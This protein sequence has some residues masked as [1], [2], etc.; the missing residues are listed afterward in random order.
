V[1]LTRA[2][3]GGGYGGLLD[4]SPC[5]RRVRLGGSISARRP[6][7]RDHGEVIR[8]PPKTPPLPADLA[9][10][11]RR[12]WAAA[13]AADNGYGRQAESLAPLAQIALVAAGYRPAAC[14]FREDVAW[15]ALP[16]GW[17]AACRRAGL[18]VGRGGPAGSIIVAR[19]RPAYDQ[20][21]A[22]ARAMRSGE[23][24]RRGGGLAGPAARLGEALG[25]PRSAIEAYALDR[26]PDS[27][28]SLFCGRGSLG[29]WPRVL[30]PFVFA[31]DPDG[32]AETLAWLR[33]A[34]RA[35]LGALPGLP[36]PVEDD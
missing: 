16:R 36:E 5:P 6:P 31:R 7:V 17:Q 22:A 28:T 4:L 32:I 33:G 35:I 24:S 2:A 1:A 18:V 29:R 27:T 19:D 8:M 13:L 10:P 34:K 12:W 26:S 23:D 15:A 21:A 30:L 20:V 11:L 14:G 3:C 9:V 25:F